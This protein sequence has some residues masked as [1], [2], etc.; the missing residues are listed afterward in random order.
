MVCYNTYARPPY[1]DNHCYQNTYTETAGKTSCVSGFSCI[2]NLIILIIVLEFLTQLICDTTC[3]D[4][5]C[6][7][8]CC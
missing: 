6:C 5:D 2:I 3:P 1:M 8:A 7:D 4:T